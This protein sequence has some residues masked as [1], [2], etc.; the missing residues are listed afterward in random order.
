MNSMETVFGIISGSLKIRVRLEDAKA[1]PG[2]RYGY[3]IDA[4]DAV[5]GD[6]SD[7]IY[8]GRGFA[9]HTAPFGGYVPSE[10]I[11]FV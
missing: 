10:Q 8:G 2:R 1:E 7:R 9:V 4:N 3:V 5:I 6:A 11:L